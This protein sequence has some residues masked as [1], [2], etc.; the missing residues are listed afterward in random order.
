MVRL[1]RVSGQMRLIA[2]LLAATVVTGAIY[3]VKPANADIH[4]L[5]GTLFFHRYSDYGSWDATMW[6]LD[7]DTGAFKQINQN[8]TTVLS[9]INAHVS[10]DGQYLTFMG[11]AAGLPN[12]DGKTQYDWDVFISHW[13]GSQWSDPINLTGGNGKR[14][15]D[16]KFSP[17]GKTI[18]YKE[19]GILA[20]VAS[21]GGVKTYL[22]IG[23]PESSMPYYRT[24]GT[25]ILFERQGKIYLKTATGDQLMDPGTGGESSYYPIGVD[26]ERFL[27]SRVQDSKHD[28][29][30]WGYYD[31]RQSTDLFFNNDTWDSSDSYPYKDAR[32]FFFLVSGDVNIPKGGYNL[33]IADLKGKKVVNIDDLYGEINSHFEELGPAWT[34]F[35]Y[36]K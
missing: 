14:D 20:T 5:S 27:F 35:T 28:G 21:T 12:I 2:G 26:N 32:D 11:S 18:V 23:E 7:L 13:E 3:M 33:V 34:S 16:P 6:S 10:T 31:G 25:D 19:D 24:N 4:D 15:E 9:P 8:W 17:N 29:I 1:G 30:R 22:S 36:S